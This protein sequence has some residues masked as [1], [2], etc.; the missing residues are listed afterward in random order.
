M[1]NLTAKNPLELIQKA[2][3]LLSDPERLLKSMRIVAHQWPNSAEVNLTNRGRNRQAW[4]GQAA[5]A[6]ESGAPESLT[7]AAWRQ[8][9][10]SQRIEANK[11][12]DIVINEWEVIR[13]AEEAIR[14]ECPP[15]YKRTN[16]MDF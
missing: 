3:D 8:L 11:V 13:N 9:T 10:E 14:N 2:R 4:L 12:A 6:L 5:C 1:Y 15:G 7:K 16:I